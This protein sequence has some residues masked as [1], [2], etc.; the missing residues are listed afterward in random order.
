MPQKM[1][2][3]RDLAYI[4]ATVRRVSALMPHTASIA[5]GANSRSGSPDWRPVS[6]KWRTSAAMSLRRDQEDKEF[7]SYV[8]RNVATAP[9]RTGTDG[10]TLA[11]GEHAFDY[12]HK[13][14][15]EGANFNR[16]MT[17]FSAGAGLAVGAAA[18]LDDF[19]AGGDD[20]R[21]GLALAALPSLAAA[22]ADNSPGARID[23]I[24]GRI[25]ADG[26]NLRIEDLRGRA[27]MQAFFKANS[28]LA[29]V[30]GNRP[31][32]RL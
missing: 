9:I 25:S 31:L 4:R 12:L 20:D 21:V 28:R 18:Q 8:S 3:A 27:G 30:H 17:S 19:A 32:I 7:A 26:P 2:E 24:A 14:P 1:S 10:P 29:L 23:R 11:Y 15:E 13:H 22:P 5:S 6:T 16:A